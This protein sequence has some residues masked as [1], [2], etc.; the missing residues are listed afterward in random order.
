[1]AW[2]HADAGGDERRGQDDLTEALRGT[3]GGDDGDEA[4][5]DDAPGTARRS[6]P[7]HG[8][9]PSTR[10]PSTPSSTLRTRAR[11]SLSVAIARR[12]GRTGRDVVRLSLPVLVGLGRPG[13]DH[14]GVARRCGVGRAAAPIG[15]RRGAAPT[16]VVARTRGLVARPDRRTGPPCRRPRSPNE[17][18]RD[19]R[20]R[21]PGA[22]SSWLRGRPRPRSPA[23]T[24]RPRRRHRSDRGAGPRRRPRD[25]RALHVRGD[26]TPS[27]RRCR[28]R[29]GCRC[30]GRVR[31]RS[32]R[33]LR[34]RSVGSR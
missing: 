23:P 18:E 16:R 31:E 7:S 2:D 11:G 28:R 14:V 25:V 27:P 9:A 15:T 4:D 12:G 24:A 19:R 8:A 5:S 21:R 6:A 20:G 32:G 13:D 33:V 17:R 1:M 26:T 30:G 34:R 10:W 22:S 3:I 29:G